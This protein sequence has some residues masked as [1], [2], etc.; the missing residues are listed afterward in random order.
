[1]EL[2]VDLSMV[3]QP[4]NVLFIPEAECVQWVTWCPTTP[5]IKCPSVWIKK[6]SELRGLIDKDHNLDK[7]LL[8]YGNNLAFMHQMCD[9]FVVICLVTW[10]LVKVRRQG[11]ADYRDEQKKWRRQRL[12]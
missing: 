6:K 5:R 11:S 9:D 10:L 1:M 7:R 2:C 3:H 4:P 12:P 8:K